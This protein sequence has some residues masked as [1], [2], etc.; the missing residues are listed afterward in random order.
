MKLI[1]INNNQGTITINNEWKIRH[2]IDGVSIQYYFKTCNT[3]YILYDPLDRKVC[4]FNI[5]VRQVSI[6]G[7]WFNYL[8]NIHL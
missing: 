7:L 1:K 4:Y 3:D 2:N 5:I 8:W 6:E